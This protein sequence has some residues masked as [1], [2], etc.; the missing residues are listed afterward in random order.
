MAAPVLSHLRPVK[1]GPILSQEDLA[2]YR[3]DETK[4]VAQAAVSFW[5][6]IRLGKAPDQIKVE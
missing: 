2:R 1:A 6:Q 3:F 5:E 4:G